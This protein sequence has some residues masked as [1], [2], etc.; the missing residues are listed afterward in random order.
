MFNK[1]N[2]LLGSLFV[3]LLS[4]TIWHEVV[5]QRV[6]TAGYYQGIVVDKT[7]S[8]GIRSSTHYLYIDW[9]AIGL[10]S[11]AVHAVTYKRAKIGDRFSTQYSYSP[12]LGATGAA[13]VPDSSEYTFCFGVVGIV[14]RLLIM[15]IVLYFIAWAAWRLHKGINL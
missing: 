15:F 9:D 1:R 8:M 3:A 7:V 5:S 6:S 11:I 10:D 4:F 14:A 12:I 13:Y 2:I